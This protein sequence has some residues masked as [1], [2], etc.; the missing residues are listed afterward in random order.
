MGRRAAYAGRWKRSSH[1]IFGC[2]SEKSARKL[3]FLAQHP[4]CCFCGGE[5]PSAEPDHVP[6]R[7]FFRNRHWP[8]GYEFPA[9]VACN[10]ATSLDEQ[11]VAML[12]RTCQNAANEDD[13]KATL[14]LM[15]EVHNNHPGLF[16]EMHPSVRDLRDARTK[17]GLSAPAGKPVTALPVLRVSGPLVNAAIDNFARKL[18]CA[19][20]Y[21]RTGRIVT[22][23]GGIG[24]R[25]YSNLQVNAD[26]IP[27]TL[28][29]VVPSI[30][31]LE[32]N[33]A[34]LNDQFF[35]RWGVTDAKT[36]AAFLAFFGQ[37]FAMLGVVRQD[38]EETGEGERVLKPFKW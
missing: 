36:M 24:F 30:P 5:T 23:A 3:R 1:V 38:A 31:V 7:V 6:G 27:R 8:V 25:W 28:V 35:Y 19:L 16:E 20:F 22:R 29:Q 18:F 12:A 37:S 14:K 13:R 11:A 26:Q 33:A 15:T 17:Y 21:M 2:M 32:R 9:C 34:L 4:V 10:R